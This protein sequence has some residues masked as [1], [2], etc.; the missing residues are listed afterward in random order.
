MIRWPNKALED[1]GGLAGSWVVGSV[2]T[3][4]GFR[5][6]PQLWRW[7]TLTAMSITLKHQKL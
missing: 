5:A 2:L 6:V 3:F 4:S 1:N 7:T